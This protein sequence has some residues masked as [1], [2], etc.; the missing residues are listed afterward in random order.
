LHKIRRRDR[1]ISYLKIGQRAWQNCSDVRKI[2]SATVRVKWGVS[3]VEN[4]RRK[5]FCNAGHQAGVSET[6]EFILKKY[7]AE[8]QEKLVRNIF[9]TGAPVQIPGVRAR[10]ETDLRE[11][12]PFKSEF[13]VC[14]ALNPVTDA[15]RGARKFAQVSMS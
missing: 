12:R 10:I 7:P 1:K 2:R 9:L 14:E 11:M 6:L 8:V 13:R 3:I 4:R 5:K 15:W